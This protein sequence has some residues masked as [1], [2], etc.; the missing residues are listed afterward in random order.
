MHRHP[1]PPTTGLD[2]EVRDAVTLVLDAAVHR[3]VDFSDPARTALVRDRLDYLARF[4]E[5]ARLDLPVPFR[6]V[7]GGLAS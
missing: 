7:S 5:A 4:V 1:V 3:R 2:Q 6:I